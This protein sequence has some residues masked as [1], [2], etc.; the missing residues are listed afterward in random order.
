MLEA[1]YLHSKITQA[2]SHRL[3]THSGHDLC[4]FH[5][6]L[7]LIFPEIRHGVAFAILD[8]NTSQSDYSKL[9]RNTVFFSYPYIQF[10]S[11]PNTSQ[12]QNKL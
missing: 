1:V 11:L 9:S 3:V 2:L 5:R 12:K 10:K 4:F 7:Y 6:N 8:N